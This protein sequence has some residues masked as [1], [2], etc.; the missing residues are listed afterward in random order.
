MREESDLRLEPFQLLRSCENVF[1]DRKRREEE[2]KKR[3]WIDLF[4]SQISSKT[5]LLCRD[6]FSFVFDFDAFSASRL[7]VLR[8][9]FFF[10]VTNPKNGSIKSNEV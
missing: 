4:C 5:A 2:G 9:T 6:F 1:V 10:S 8:N 7:Y 3:S